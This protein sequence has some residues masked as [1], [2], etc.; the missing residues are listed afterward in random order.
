MSHFIIR[1]I[2]NAIAIAVTSYL[3]P[4]MRIDG[5]N[6]LFTLAVVAV[7]FGVLNA[8]IKPILAVLTCPLYILTLGLFTFVVNAAMLLLTSAIAQNVGLGFH[9]DGWLTAIIGSILI[10]IV[11]FVL[12]LFLGGNKQRKN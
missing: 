8:V 5:N 12:S 3:L 7:I 2:V 9:V 6:Y 10:S 11:S 4:G 1:V